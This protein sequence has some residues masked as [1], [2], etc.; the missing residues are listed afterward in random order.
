MDEK[1]STIITIIILSSIILVFTAGDLIQKDRFYSELENK[2]LAAKPEF[3][4]EAVFEGE[5]TKKY[6]TY[7]T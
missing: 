4:L 7:L 5:Y 3:S 2:V 1:R 6:E